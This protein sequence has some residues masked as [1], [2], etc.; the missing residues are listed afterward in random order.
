MYEGRGGVWFVITWFYF[1]WYVN[2]ENFTTWLV[3]LRF[4]VTRGEL[5][6]LT[7]ILDLTTLF[8]VILRRELVLRMVRVIYREWLRHGMRFAI[9]NLDLAL[10]DFAFCKHSFLWKNTLFKRV[11]YLPIIVIQENETFV[12]VIRDPLFQKAPKNLTRT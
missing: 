11:S 9:W 5:E 3:I 1:P 10:R 6:L 2:L 12:S 8:S 4:C 7:D